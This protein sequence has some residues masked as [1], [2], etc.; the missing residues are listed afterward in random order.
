MTKRFSSW[1][2]FGDS[3]S[4][5]NPRRLSRFLECVTFPKPSRGP[6]TVS[7]ISFMQVS[8]DDGSRYYDATRKQGNTRLFL[9]AVPYTTCS[10]DAP[11]SRS[12]YMVTSDRALQIALQKVKAW[13]PFRECLSPAA[14][15]ARV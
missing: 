3:A 9:A 12:V 14:F 10:P 7:A 6:L 8:N 11:G 13:S 1:S 4:H 5:R 15:H 2:D